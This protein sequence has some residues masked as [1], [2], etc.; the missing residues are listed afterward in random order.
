VLG[1][2]LLAAIAA[3]AYAFTE[4]F[5]RPRITRYG[6]LP[7]GWP[8]G[9]ELSIAVVA[10]IHACEPWMTP[11]RVSAIVE[12]TNALDADLIL[13]LGDYLTTTRF[14]TAKV[15][16][17][18]VS[19]RLSHLSAPLGVYAILGNHDYSVDDAVQRDPKREP[20]IA[21]RLRA[22][23]IPTLINES[24]RL[25]KDGHAFWLA[26]LA[27]QLA[28]MPAKA[29]GRSSFV[30][31]DNLDA[32]L[33]D[34]PHNDPVLLLA[35]EPDIFPKVGTRASLPLSGHTHGG[36][37]DILGWRPVSA[38]SGSKRFPAGH[39]EVDG[40]HLIVSKGL[41]VSGLPFRVGCWPEILLL[42]LG[43]P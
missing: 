28:L 33:A 15:S 42:Q 3:P 16:P 20:R 40:H 8:T 38:S 12:Q 21:A 31:L 41:G 25:S 18:V 36:Q 24:L 22:V 4:V 9:L 30:G 23:G 19:E 26:G 13:L 32:T 10:D 6:L 29:Y 14:V 39:F 1:G 34:I 11:A 17:S 35:H 2:A 7:P 37:I 43:T 5:G 27:D